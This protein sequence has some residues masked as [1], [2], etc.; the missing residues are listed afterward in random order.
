MQASPDFSSGTLTGKDNN[1]IISGL[2]QWIDISPAHRTG[3]TSKA[4]GRVFTRIHT[5]NEKAQRQQEYTDL[6]PSVNPE[7]VSPGIGTVAFW[8]NRMT[9]TA[10]G[11]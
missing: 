2:E 3:D 7:A 5:Y 1:A 11:A 4:T 10:A 6:L 9:E 8:L